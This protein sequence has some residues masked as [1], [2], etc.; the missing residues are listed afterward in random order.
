M[1]RALNDQRTTNSYTNTFAYT[2]NY[3][4]SVATLGYPS[5][6]TITYTPSV[7][8]Q[9]VSAVDSTGTTINYAIGPSTCPNGNSASSLA[10]YNPDGS[11][12]SVQNGSSLISTFYNNTRLQPCRMA[13]NVGGTPPT[14]CGDTTS[15]H[16]GNDMD[17][18]YNFN[19]GSSDNGNVIKITDNTA[20][21]P[22]ITYAYDTLNRIDTANSDATSGSLCSGETYTIDTWSN[23]TGIGTSSGY[24][25]TGCTNETLSLSVNGSNQ[26]TNTNFAYDAAGNM[27]NDGGSHS[28]TYD[29]E[30]RISTVGSSLNYY[31]DGDG[32]RVR[33]SGGTMY[34]YGMNGAPL[35]ETDSSGNP[36]YE[37]IFFDGQRT[38]RRDSSSNVE[39]YFADHLGSARV[40]TNAGGTV[41]EDCFY[42]SYGAS[43]CSPSSVDNYLFAGKERDGTTLSETGLDYSGA[44][45]YSSQFGRFMTPDPTGILSANLSDP[46]TLNFYSYVRNSPLSLTDPTGM[47]DS[48]CTDFNPGCDYGFGR[49]FNPDTGCGG[50]WGACNSYSEISGSPGAQSAYAGSGGDGSGGYCPAGMSTCGGNGGCT[51]DGGPISCNLAATGIANGSMAACPS[52]ATCQYNSDGLFGWSGLSILAITATCGTISNTC[53]GTEWTNTGWVPI[54]SGS[55]DSDPNGLMTRYPDIPPRPNT[56]P[57]TWS[58]FV[59]DFLPCYGGELIHNVVGDGSGESDAYAGAFVV[60]NGLAIASGGLFIPVAAIWDLNVTLRAGMTC[61]EETR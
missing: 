36:T 14:S 58:G 51:L 28:Y 57:A 8:G 49:G 59:N 44:R 4:G 18:T 23:L 29:A 50:D 60:V 25:G 1:G 9:P 26:I 35:L 43:G 11:L 7:V 2:Y 47:D 5:G 55:F 46:Q 33:K 24:G 22:N 31:Y 40:V 37:Y 34:W 48:D 45:H 27:T 16:G 10:C 61:R 53:S 20:T 17:L 38:A 6:H 56:R 42:Y 12:A 19:L 39:Y 41:L 15:G 54:G 13:V 32:K 52:S 3:D 30:S 21:F